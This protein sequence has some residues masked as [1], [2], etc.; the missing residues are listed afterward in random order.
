M[1]LLYK[2]MYEWKPLNEL[3]NTLKENIDIIFL[4]ITY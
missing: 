2:I 1:F 3:K 4:K